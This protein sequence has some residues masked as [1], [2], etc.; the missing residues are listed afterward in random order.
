MDVA[1]SVPQG[2]N[3]HMDVLCLSAES[4]E[5][6]EELMILVVMPMPTHFPPNCLILRLTTLLFILFQGGGVLVFFTQS[7]SG[8]NKYYVCKWTCSKTETSVQFGDKQIS[9]IINQ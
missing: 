1:L 8:F 7:L 4:K 9:K 2:A 6:S 5:G 3:Y